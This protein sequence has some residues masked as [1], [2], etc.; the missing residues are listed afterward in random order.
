MVELN[1]VNPLY[2]TRRSNCPDHPT[3]ANAQNG[4]END[5]MTVHL[6]RP[7][8]MQMTDKVRL[9]NSIRN[10]VQLIFFFK[11]ILHRILK[12]KHIYCLFI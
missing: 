2:L 8:A 5:A 11:G 4:C 6:V 7:G 12:L 1:K 9:T 10:Q 3:K